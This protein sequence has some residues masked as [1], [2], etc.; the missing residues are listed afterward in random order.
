MGFQEAV[1]SAFSK[2]ATFS[3]RARRAEY[4]WFTLF[5]ALASVVLSILDATLLGHGGPQS[6]PFDGLWSLIAFLPS[7]SVMVRRLHDVNRSGWWFWIVL[8]PLV[9]ALIL[10]WWMIKPGDAGDND[11]GPDPIAHPDSTQIPRVPRR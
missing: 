1:R 8:I 7:L 10:L 11:F 4:W 6:G 2:F 3:G 5:C 9:G